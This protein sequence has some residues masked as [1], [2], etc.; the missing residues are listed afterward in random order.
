MYFSV[1]ILWPS[2]INVY[3]SAMLAHVDICKCVSVIYDNVLCNY[4][5]VYNNVLNNK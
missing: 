5:F 3:I 4:M 1:A 2:R